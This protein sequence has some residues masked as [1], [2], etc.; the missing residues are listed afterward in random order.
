MRNQL[1]AAG[2]LLTM[3]ALAACGTAASAGKPKAAPPPPREIMTR[4]TNI[5]T[6][7]TTGRGTTIYWFSADA[8]KVSH[9][10]GG[11]AKYWPPV[12]GPAVLAAGLKL[13]GK[14]G[15][16]TRPGGFVQATYDGHPLYTYLAD[17]TPGETAGNMLNE[18]GG[19]WW[20]ITPSGNR[21]GAPASAG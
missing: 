21:L 4:H 19:L 14:F 7:L 3:L 2:L 20:A 10:T 18:S 17:T 11:C 15:T 1:Q 16:I 12:E 9:C 6:V 8:A 13:P 5:G